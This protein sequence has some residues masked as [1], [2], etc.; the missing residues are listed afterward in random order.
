MQTDTHMNVIHVLNVFHI[1]I[2][3]S[4]YVCENQIMHPLK[5]NKNRIKQFDLFEKI[6]SLKVKV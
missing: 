6:M 2:L 4:L 3:F 5:W 1:N